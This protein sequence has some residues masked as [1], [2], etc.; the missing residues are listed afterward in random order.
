MLDRLAD[1]LLEREVL[2]G[3]ELKKLLEDAEAVPELA[4]S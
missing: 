1:I 3:P 2:E 4:R